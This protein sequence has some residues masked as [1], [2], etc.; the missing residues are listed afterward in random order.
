M[1]KK[2]IEIPFGAFDSEL[3]GW[4]YTIP[5]GYEAVV[6]NGKVIVRKSESEDEKIRKDLINGFEFYREHGEYWGTE[7]FPLKITD[8][9]A[10]LEKGEQKPAETKDL[11]TWKPSEEQ[12][13]AVRIAAEIGTANDS[14]AMGILKSMYRELKHL[15]E[16]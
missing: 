13:E 15:M 12:I 7:K 5:E 1:E 10:W 11:R 6:E 14:W 9:I 3:G 8:I 16:E 2:D 4:E